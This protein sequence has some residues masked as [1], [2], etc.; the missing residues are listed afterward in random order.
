[1]IVE[2]LVLIVCLI[3]YS[4]YNKRRHLPPGP[5]SVPILGTVE[6]FNGK[7]LRS[8]DFYKYEDMYTMFLGPTTAIVIN[9]FQ[10]AKDLFFRD[11]FSGKRMSSCRY[12]WPV[13]SLPIHIW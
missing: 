1:M 4:Q 13:L 3:F 11:E 5:F 10:R 8:P 12:T 2:L 6:I 9:D 7:N